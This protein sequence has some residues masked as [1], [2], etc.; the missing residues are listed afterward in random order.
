MRPGVEVAAA[1]DGMAG[2]AAVPVVSTVAWREDDEA[3]EFD[4]KALGIL[5]LR[6]VPIV[7]AK[8]D[9]DEVQANV[10]DEQWQRWP[11]TQKSDD[12]TR[13]VVRDCCWI[14]L[15]IAKWSWDEQ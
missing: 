15:D 6:R 5:V 11:T 8:D 14:I 12:A 9:D 2:A 10:V 1:D 7:V 4:R 3:K 13:A